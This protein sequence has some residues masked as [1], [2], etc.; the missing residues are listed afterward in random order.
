MVSRKPIVGAVYGL[1][2]AV[3]PASAG[4]ELEAAEAGFNACQERHVAEISEAFAQ[5][6]EAALALT[7]RCLDSY[8]GFIRAEARLRFDTSNE[9]RMYRNERNATQL[10]IEASLPVIIRYR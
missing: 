10:K 8:T 1:L 7:N 6:A 3:T 4:T 9:Q 5:A 2:L